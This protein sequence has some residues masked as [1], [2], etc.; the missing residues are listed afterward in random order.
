[1]DVQ[2]P[3]GTVVKGVP[4]GMS[5]DDLVAKL[6]A[7]GHDVSWHKP[8]ATVEGGMPSERPTPAA[9]SQGF[10]LSAD[11]PPQPDTSITQ[12]IGVVNKAISPYALAAGTG[13]LMGAPIGGVGAIPGAGLGVMALGA[14][15]IGTSLYNAAAPL[16]NGQRV[17]TPSETIRQGMVGAGF[18]REPQTPEQNMLY[19]GASGAASGLTGAAGFNAL[20]GFTTG[21]TNK[22]LGELASNPINQ[23]VAGAGGALLPTAMN[24]YADVTNPAALLGGSI[25]GTILGS[26]AAGKLPIGYG[27]MPKPETPISAADLEARAKASFRAAGESGAVYDPQKFG[28]F[29]KD[30]ESKLTNNDYFKDSNIHDPIKA[31]FKR[32]EQATTEAQKLSWMHDFRQAIGR[33]STNE[34]KDVQRLANIMR[35]EFDNFVTDPTNAVNATPNAY[36]YQPATSVVAPTSTPARAASNAQ[37]NTPTSNSMNE[38]NRVTQSMAG[39]AAPRAYESALVEPPTT[40]APATVNARPNAPVSSNMNEWNRVTQRMGAAPPEGL[41]LP[42]AAESQA[43][44]NQGSKALMSGIDDWRVLMRSDEIE[45]IINNA[46]IDAKAGD[47]NFADTVRQ[48]FASLARNEDRMK[49]F[50]LPEQQAIMDI[51]EGNS[52]GRGTQLLARL[53]PDFKGPWIMNNVG[54]ALGGAFLSHGLGAGALTGALLMP[55]GA[56]AGAGANMLRNRNAIAAA[57]ELA[58]NTRAGQMPLTPYTNFAP[59]LPYI[60]NALAG[61]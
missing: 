21:T 13:A 57:N 52:S 44:V 34:S 29:I 49:R 33:A 3:D 12:N 42:A 32:A 17:N 61:R 59:T 47:K 51:V 31:L 23:T 9:S 4:D 14:G 54:R 10:Q 37:P 26:R 1:M 24:Q 58:Q 45:S 8:S 28:S 41:T 36:A 15:D 35:D 2:L 27:G 39:P 5:K 50:S 22:V 16:W 38:W 11:I 40:I 55:S 20:R 60:T 25:A 19:Q 56:V 48:R 53:A 46:K 18:A 43:N 6:K 7:S 30:L